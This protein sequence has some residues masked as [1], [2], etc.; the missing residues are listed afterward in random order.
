[1]IEWRGSKHI[2]HN[3]SAYNTLQVQVVNHT[4]SITLRII[5]Q[6][7]GVH[8]F[9]ATNHI[10]SLPNDTTEYIGLQVLFEFDV[11]SFPHGETPG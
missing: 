7:T 9:N 8:K 4:T 3:A 1:M 5:R 2:K 6:S 11:H 10:T